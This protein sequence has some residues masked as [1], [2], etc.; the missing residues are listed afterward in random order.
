V[1]DLI[2]TLSVDFDKW[3][4]FLETTNTAS[5]KEFAPLTQ[6]IKVAIKKLSIDLNDLSQTIDI[7]TAN[8]QRFRDIDDKELDSRKKFVNDM[9]ALVSDYEETLASVRTKSKLERDA[10][11]VCTPLDRTARLCRCLSLA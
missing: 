2:G 1:Q 4:E 11:E 3:K 10:R 7:V 6:S 9:K 8:R 5:N